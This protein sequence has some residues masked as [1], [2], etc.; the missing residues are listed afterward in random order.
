MTGDNVMISHKKNR[1]WRQCLAC[2]RHA[3][4]NPPMASILAIVDVIKEKIAKGSISS[5]NTFDQ[6]GQSCRTFRISGLFRSG[7][8]PNPASTLI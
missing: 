1:Q 4:K 3:A 7:E 5:I 8:W 6:P 2:R